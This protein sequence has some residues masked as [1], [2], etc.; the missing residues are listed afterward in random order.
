MA[1]GWFRA[2][3]VLGGLIDMGQ[4]LRRG[5]APST[6]GGSR[7]RDT[8]ALSGSGGSGG[9]L[10]ARLAGVLVA[11]L[12]EAFDRDRTR[13][14]LEQ[15]QLESERRRAEDAM[16]LE[17]RRQAGD[18]ALGQARLLAV[19]A[20]V[21]WIA[22][23]VL[24]AFLPGARAMPARGVLALGWTLLL[25]CAG[26][27]FAFHVSVASWLGRLRPGAADPGE[28][29]SEVLG[30]TSGFLLIAGLAALAAALLLSV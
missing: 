24:F 26:T 17:L 22:S 14:E 23:A 30:R 15:A 12:K 25:G 27:A 6:G 20:V 5:P 29:P 2:L 18:R 28:V 1:A 4:R 3:E 8:D 16:R 10:E 13:L 9:P 19:L 21:A 7:D 11:A